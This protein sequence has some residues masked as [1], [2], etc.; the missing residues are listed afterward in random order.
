MH[1]TAQ[2]ADSIKMD[3]VPDIDIPAFS[4]TSMAESDDGQAQEI[5]GLLQSSHDV[6]VSMAGY[7][8]GPARFRI[9]GLDSENLAVLMGGVQLNDMETG[10]VYW[11]N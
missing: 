8:F 4:L 11:S 9:R 5:A 2:E 3:T 10:R 7:T 1:T 6:F